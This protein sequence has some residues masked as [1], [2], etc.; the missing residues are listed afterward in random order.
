MLIR[1]IWKFTYVIF[2]FSG[3][4]AIKTSNSFT[5]NR[6]DMV[7]ILK[8]FSHICHCL[9]GC[10]I[11]ILGK[12]KWYMYLLSCL[13]ATRCMS[14]EIS[15][16]YWHF[17]AILDGSSHISNWELIDKNVVS[18]HVK[19]RPCVIYGAE[20][21]KSWQRIRQH[22]KV[23]ANER[24]RQ[25]CKVF[26]HSPK[27]KWFNFDGILSLAAVE[28]VLL[29]ASSASRDGNFIKIKPFSFQCWLRPYLSIDWNRAWI[30]FLF[31]TLLWNNGI[32]CM[33]C[34]VLIFNSV[35]H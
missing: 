2:G 25:K 26:L 32:R 20:T 17:D 22:C 34:Y 23:L 4:D 27:R 10:H 18:L 31:I 24:R 19:P 8:D 7:W 12:V 33:S 16:K 1:D 30:M 6:R 35:V 11:C 13:F 14:F 29:T 5:E 9:V 21:T 28:V 3:V 15:T